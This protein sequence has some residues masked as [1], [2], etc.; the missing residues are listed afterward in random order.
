[1]LKTTSQLGRGHAALITLSGLILLSALG[2]V[3]LA[4]TKPFGVIDSQRIVTEYDAA[5]DAQE[6]YAKFLRE[7]EKEI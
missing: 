5:R 1:M 7:L 2:G 3:A 4:D 6:Q